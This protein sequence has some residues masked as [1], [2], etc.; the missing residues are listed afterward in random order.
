[1]RL[2]PACY[3]ELTAVITPVTAADEATKSPH[4]SACMIRCQA[5]ARI[6]WSRIVNGR[7]E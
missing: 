7:Q 2:R 5:D 1:M 6:A 4:R 3:T